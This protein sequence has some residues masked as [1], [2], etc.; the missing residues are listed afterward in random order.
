MFAWMNR[1]SLVETVSTGNAV[2]LVP[3]RQRLWRKG[4]ESPA[5]P[6]NPC[7]SYRLRWR[8]ALLAIEQEGASLATR[9]ARAVL[10]NCRGSSGSR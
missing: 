3:F 10:T 7:H 5:F 6:A 1:E 9:A 4:E 2:I 8:R